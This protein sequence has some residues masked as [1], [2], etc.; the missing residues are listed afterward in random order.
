MLLRLA[1]A[2]TGAEVTGDS[3][4]RHGVDPLVYVVQQ[5]VFHIAKR[6][7]EVDVHRQLFQIPAEVSD[8]RTNHT[9]GLRAKVI[10]RRY[11]SKQPR[12]VFRIDLE[13]SKRFPEVFLQRG[14]N[15]DLGVDAVIRAG[16]LESFNV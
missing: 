3:Q 16:F 8:G 11:A 12:H 1:R 15:K 4:H 10:G 9:L 7:T 13:V 14:V 5:N 2:V 6:R